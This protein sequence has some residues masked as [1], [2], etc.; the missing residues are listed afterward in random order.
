MFGRMTRTNP[1]TTEYMESTPRAAHL[2]SP[3]PVEGRRPDHTVA[4]GKA[5]QL[6]RPPVPGLS[7]TTREAKLEA[8]CTLS[9]RGALAGEAE[10]RGG[11][12]GGSWERRLG[13]PVSVEGAVGG[14]ERLNTLESTLPGGEDGGGDDVLGGEGAE[15]REEA[16]EDEGG[17]HERGEEGEEAR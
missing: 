1:T 3:F 5:A 16:V 10:W 8:G 13:A 9:P 11:G 14:E 2:V 17:G 6:K 7:R 15:P 12:E 4:E